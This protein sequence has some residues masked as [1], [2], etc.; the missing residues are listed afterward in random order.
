MTPEEVGERMV[1]LLGGDVTAEVS[2]G[3][4]YARATVDVPRAKWYRAVAGAR[5]AG[6]LSC[7]FFDWLSA[8]DELADGFSVVVHLWSTRRRHGVLLRTR[9]PRDEPTLE[10]VVELF[11]GADW[12]ER[13]THEMFGIDFARHPGLRPLLL[14]DGFEGHPL[15]KEFVLASR[16]VKA[17]PGAKEPGESEGTAPKRA[18]VRP[19]G[20]PDP[21][22]WGPL[23]GTLPETAAPSRPA[24]GPRPTPTDRPPRPPRPAAAGAATAGPATA[25]PA[26]PDKVEPP[27]EPKPSPTSNPSAADTD[28]AAAP[29]PDGEV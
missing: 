9:V 1:A 13:E 12:H 22:E 7:D 24:R 3:G 18:A 15:R 4:G 14:P 26:A 20:V 6:V 10:S 5:E 16:V 21:N 23:A 25:G 17:W 29:R 8:V 27:A 28:P 2:G 11:P 19:P